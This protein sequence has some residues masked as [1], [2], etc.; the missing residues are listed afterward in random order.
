MRTESRAEDRPGE[1]A[2]RKARR[3]SVLGYGVWA[4]ALAWFGAEVASSPVLA[5]APGQPVL[6]AP[7]LTAPAGPG[8]DGQL[9]AG[10]L[11]PVGQGPG[12]HSPNSPFAPLQPRSDVVPWSSLTAVKMK[13]VGRRLLPDFPANVRALHGTTVRVQGFMMPLAPGEK[14]SHF[15]VSSVPLTCAFCT[16]GGPESML[17]VRTRTPVKYSQ[18]AVVVEGRLH[19]LDDDPQGLYYRMT[20]AVAVK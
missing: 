18:E 5:Q 1:V 9:P 20:F 16:P 12:Q 19:V 13:T 15:L 11:P 6:T 7:V 17:E 3:W 8:A 4:M 2:W 14:Q 10:A